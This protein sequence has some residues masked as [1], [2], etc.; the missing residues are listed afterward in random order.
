MR[1]K[2]KKIKKIK[3][4]SVTLQITH[5]HFTHLFGTLCCI[6]RFY[7]DEIDIVYLNLK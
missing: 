6:F 4:F 1:E 5:L 7:Y 2:N 3:K